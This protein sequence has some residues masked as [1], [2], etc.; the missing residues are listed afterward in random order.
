MIVAAIWGGAFVAVKEAFDHF[1]PFTVMALRFSIAS[2]VMYAFMWKKIG[3]CSKTDIKYGFILGFISFLAF[4][5]Q[6]IGLVYTTVS[7]Q[8]L[9]TALYVIIVPF[10]VWLLYKNPPNIKIFFSAFIALIGIGLMSLEDIGNFDLNIG[11]MLTIFSASMYALVII[12]VDKALYKT[13]AI[14]LTFLQLPF[15]AVFLGVPALIFEP[16][17]KNLTMSSWYSVIY[18]GVFA[19]FICYLMQISAQKHTAP[20]RASLLMSLE[21]PFAVLFAVIILGE[22][23]SRFQIIGMVLMLSALVLVE[24]APR[25]KPKLKDSVE[26]SV[27]DLG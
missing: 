18:L 6:T 24:L 15:S 20:S 17:P 13:D 26:L 8:G 19:T 9:F 7:K 12:F 2:I 10:L 5:A 14:K 1:G 22:S 16:F 11:D 27:N 25:R 4:G 21:S 3:R 23:L